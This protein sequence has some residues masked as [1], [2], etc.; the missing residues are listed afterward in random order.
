MGFPGRFQGWAWHTSQE[1]E[2]FAD[3]ELPGPLLPSSTAFSGLLIRDLGLCKCL[4]ITPQGEFAK[5]GASGDAMERELG[6]RT[7]KTWA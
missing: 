6:F 3:L 4:S 2:W 1:R 5:L 7:G